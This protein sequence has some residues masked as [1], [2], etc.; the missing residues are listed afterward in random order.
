M[1]RRHR[2]HTLQCFQPTLG[3]TGFGRFG[4]ETTDKVLHLPNFSLLL[5]VL[6]TLLCHALRALLFKGRIPPAIGY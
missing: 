2:F 3:L 4:A 1:G 5:G 6:R